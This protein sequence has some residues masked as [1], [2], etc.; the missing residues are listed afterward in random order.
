ME[1]QDVFLQRTFVALTNLLNSPEL[2]EVMAEYSF[3]EK[4][5]RQGLKMHGKVETL[6]LQREQAQEAQYQATQLLTQA[7][8]DLMS[9]YRKHLET[10]RLAYLR[11]AAD[12]QDT[13]HITATV[14]RTMVDCIKHIKRF[15]AHV[16]VPMMEKYLVPQK[17]LTEASRLA[18]RVNE[19]L[20]L[21]IKAKSQ[22]Q[23]LSDLRQKEL[24]ALQAWMHR[25]EKIAR[26][27]FEE[28]PQQLEVLGHTVR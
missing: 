7:K 21:Q 27:A 26:I 12:Y 23:Q 2:L 25:F 5:V 28:Q 17:E 18:Q 9:I 4:K 8:E 10:A 3:D 15:Y 6:T 24:N 11:E 19:L 13:L 20:A 16:P 22:P 14:P 1:R